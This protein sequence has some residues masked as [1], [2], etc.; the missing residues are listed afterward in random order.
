MV[1]IRMV[2]AA[3]TAAV[4]LS[5]GCASLTSTPPE[6]TASGAQPAAQAPAAG[7]AS[8]VT[9]DGYKKQAAKHIVA[10]SPQAFEGRLPEIL[11]SVVVL[12]LTV[13]REGKVVKV[14]VRRSNGYKDLEATA[15]ESVRR[16]GRLPAPAF[17]VHRGTPTISYVETW[18][19]RDDGKFQIRSLVV[20]PQP[21]ATA[22]AA[23]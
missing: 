8:A 2:R 3:V 21:G 13:D 17:A 23:N 18:L 1:H 15:L 12:D 19:F 5:A 10:S 9:M 20:E 7:T 11:K 16:A 22:S 14:S 6:G 4:A